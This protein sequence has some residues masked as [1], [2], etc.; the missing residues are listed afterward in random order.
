MNEILK[1]RQEIQLHSEELHEIVG[2]PPGRM[3]RWGTSLI[4]VA[5]IIML[6]VS[7]LVKYADVLGGPFVLLATNAPKSVIVH[8][9]G[10]LKNL[11]VKDNDSVRQ[12]QILAFMESNADH[13]EVIKL[14]EDLNHLWELIQHDHW[15][16]IAQFTTSNYKHLGELQ[17]AYQQFIVAYIQLGA[18][19]RNGMYAQ[20]KEL[21]L[22][23]LSNLYVLRQNYQSQQKVYQQDLE[24][25]EEHLR[26]IKKLYDEKVV[27]LLE[28]RQDI[29]NCLSKKL[30]VENSNLAL[31]KN[32]ND[33]ANKQ[34]EQVQLDQQFNDQ[35][36][37]FLQA[38]NTLTSSTD[39]W[40]KRFL[41]I[42]PVSGRVTWPMLLQAAQ[43]VKNGQEVFYI[44][45]SS[46]N[47]YGEVK[48]AQE[49]FGKLQLKQKVLI[50]LEGY[51]YQEYG[52]L[53]GT[54]T[55]ISKVPDKTGQYYAA[56]NFCNGLTTDRNLPVTFQN[57][58]AGTAEIITKKTRLIFKLLYTMREVL[59]K[60]EPIKNANN[61]D[62]S[63]Q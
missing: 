11:F 23:E 42:A 60:P 46:T 26:A 6:A 50:T 39:D 22:Q 16:S 31:T 54:V 12:G 10:K 58:L 53:E 7:V 47:Y 1:P 21:L 63:I 41:L 18:F 33:I 43:D 25:A 17:S 44:S 15:E 56:I 29:S 55:F 8:T 32:Q 62:T 45:P 30:P 61:K 34:Q 4:F 49:N 9:D 27:P 14:S 57:G 51:P 40:E 52:K 5:L 35:K 13:K 20:K 48:V 28:Y 36:S 59:Y 37:S 19:L 38:L 24:I 2:R 3:I